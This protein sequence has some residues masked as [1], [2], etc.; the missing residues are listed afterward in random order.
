MTIGPDDRQALFARD[1][2][3]VL[4]VREEQQIDGWTVTSIDSE[5]V[6]LNSDFGER[7][8][9]PTSSPRSVAPRT[10][11]PARVQQAGAKPP[12][13]PPRPTNNTT[14]NNTKSAGKS[15]RS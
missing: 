6:V 3:G 10:P 12:A 11:A 14:N 4:A 9:H 15:P 1:G 2:G 13:P 5:K 7:V 8:L